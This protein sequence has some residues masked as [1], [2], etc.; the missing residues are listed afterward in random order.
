MAEPNSQQDQESSEVFGQ[1]LANQV[2]NEFLK[3]QKRNRRW[4]IF[5]K[6]L[7]AIY[8][9]GFLG[10]Y[11]GESMD[12]RGGG[13]AGDKHTA[14]I[15][16]EGAI[17]AGE[18]AS[19]DNIVSGLRAAY[20]NKKTAGIILRINSPGGSPVQSGYINDE[21]FRLK[22]KHP[23]IP[24]YAVISD[25][26][27]SGGY[28]IASAADEIYAD[29][30]SLVGSIGVIM[31]GFGFVDAID[32]LGVERRV[33]HA[34]ENKAFMDPFAPLKEDE[35]AHVDAMLDEIYEQ[36]KA[37]VKKGRE[38]KLMADDE[39]VFSGL[40][41]TGERAVDIGL[42]DK[43]GSSSYVA[44]EVIGAE[45]IINFSYKPNYL[46]RFAERLGSS[47]GN[48]LLSILKIYIN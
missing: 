38:G 5:F 15:E 45:D 34:G 22:E 2:A 35:V 27:A 10:I 32:K 21:I 18:R 3:E 33:L 4:G 14:L 19:A 42:V 47:V 16:V 11:L 26:C 31:A 9:L 43:L 7:F 46:D 1:Q 40:L 23:D 37:V 28:Y 8:L 48:S 24:I 30:A 44:R 36:F 41:W 17:G 12:M 13:L 39:T 29:K 6:F 25:I 20:E